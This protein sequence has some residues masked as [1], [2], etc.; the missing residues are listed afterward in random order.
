M[1]KLLYFKVKLGAITSRD[2]YKMQALIFLHPKKKSQIKVVTYQT[3][4]KLRQRPRKHS[5]SFK[6]LNKNDFKIASTFHLLP[7]LPT[8]SCKVEII[9]HLIIPIQFFFFCGISL[10]LFSL[11]VSSDI[12]IEENETQVF[13]YSFS[14]TKPKIDTSTKQHNFLS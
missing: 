2:S 5:V 13:L 10:M 3:T 11:Q 12:D 14:I 9:F 8:C 1:N 6:K 7:L 4:K